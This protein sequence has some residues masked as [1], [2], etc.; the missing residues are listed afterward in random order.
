MSQEAKEIFE[1]GPFRLDLKEH[2]LERGDGQKVGPIPEKAFQTLVHLVRHSGSLVRKNELVAAIWPDTIVE[3]NNLD[4]AI[5]WIRQILGE[6]PGGKKYIE[7]VRKH[8]YRFVASVNTLGSPHESVAAR[9]G[10]VEIL[11]ELKAIRPVGEPII[12]SLTTDSGAFVV[13]A[14]WSSDNDENTVQENTTHDNNLRIS[15]ERQNAGLNRGFPAKR[16]FAL[17]VVLLLALSAGLLS[18]ANYRRAHGAADGTVSIAVLPLHPIDPVNR[19]DLYEIGTA[20]AII[21]QLGAAK[22]IVVRPLSA[23][24]KYMEIEQDLIAAGREQKVDYVL[25]SNYQIANG[26]IKVTS[27]LLN[28]ATGKVEDTFS[29]EKDGANLFSAQEAIAADLGGRINARFGT[30]STE[31][32]S[33]RGTNNEEAYSLYFQAVNLSEERGVQNVRRSLEHFERAVAL[34]PNYALAWAGKDLIHRDMVGHGAAGQHEHYQKSM[35]A[36][37]KA[38]A[39]DPN[40]SDAYSALCHNKNRYEYDFTGAEMACKRALELDP[41]SPVA[42]KVYANF[43]YTRGRFDESIAEIKTAMELQPV[44]YQN[45]QIYALALYFAR[46]YPEAEDQFKRLVELNPNHSYIHG[47]LVKVLEQQGKYPE[48]FGYLIEMLAIQKEDEMAERFKV[49]YRTKGWRGV[50][51]EQI[52]AAENQEY[53]RFFHIACLYAKIGGRDK[54]LENLEKAFLE[55]N[56]QMPILKVEPQLDSLRADPRFVDLVKRVEGK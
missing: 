54:A 49:A 24:R 42:H 41:H 22:R 1:F 14:K 15:V 33:K 28:V 20:D 27:Q 18:F 52:I 56:F 53:Q 17:A 55:R 13:S 34:D 4:K 43:L 11:N 51:N 19:N 36:L 10:D 29:V 35:E 46:R 50:M 8:G 12:S 31:F 48:A 25:A 16:K 7:T 32:R 30:E 37:N 3:E 2:R 39:I 38:L 47:S 5:H 23:T 21:H 26:R 40:L 45:Q 44:S 9:Q 6:K